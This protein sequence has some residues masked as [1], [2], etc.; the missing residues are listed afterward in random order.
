MVFAV[1]AHLD[2][3]SFRQHYAQ[4]YSSSPALAPLRAFVKRQPSF[5]DDIAFG[6]FVNWASG[7]PAVCTDETATR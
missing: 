5:P 2:Y 3:C 1:P 6:S 7:A 4:E